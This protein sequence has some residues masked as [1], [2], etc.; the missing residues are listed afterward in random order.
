MRFRVFPFLFVVAL[1]GCEGKAHK[2]AELQAQY[3][4]AYAA[5]TKDCPTAGGS[6]GA[7]RLLTGEKLTQAQ[8]AELEAKRKAEEARCK[9]E[10]D[11]LADLQR[12]ILAAQQ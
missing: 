4:T 1:A 5:Y 12:Q 2:V 10:A 7:A 11:H 8:F 6:S 9:P 3:N